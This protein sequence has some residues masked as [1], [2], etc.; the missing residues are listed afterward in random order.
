[1]KAFFGKIVKAKY[2]HICDGC[3]RVIKKGQFYDYSDGYTP[4]YKNEIGEP[5]RK[6]WQFKC[7]ID[8]DVDI[9]NTNSI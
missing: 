9:E 7:H 1:M 5:E 8:C 6:Y 3:N 2:Y 4:T